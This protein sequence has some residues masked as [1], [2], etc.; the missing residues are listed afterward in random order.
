MVNKLNQEF[1]DHNLMIFHTETKAIEQILNY[2]NKEG[3]VDFSPI[4]KDDHFPDALKYFIWAKPC[5]KKTP[6][7]LTHN[8]RLWKAIDEQIHKSSGSKGHNKLGNCY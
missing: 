3:S 6:E 8:Q 4:K 1:Y 2:C 5:K 7:N